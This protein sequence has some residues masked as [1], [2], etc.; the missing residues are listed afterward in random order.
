MIVAIVKV[1]T[2]IQPVIELRPASSESA[3]VSDYC[4]EYTPPL[5]PADYFG[6]DAGALD[7]L[8]FWSYNFGTSSFTEDLERTQDFLV[9]CIK[10]HRDGVRLEADVLAEYP[11]SS[12]KMF[13]CSIV[14][15]DNWSKLATLDAQGAVVYPF[16]VTTHDERGSYDLIDTADREAATL[17]VSIAVL[18]ERASAEVYIAAVLAAVTAPDARVAAEPYLRS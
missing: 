11:S 15:Q 18:T 3:A 17:A 14:S 10:D 13:S 12:G 16:R 9:K 7:P 5:N 6:G 8:F 4:N 1:D 2:G